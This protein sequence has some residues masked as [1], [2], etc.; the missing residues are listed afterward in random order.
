MQF[1]PVPEPPADRTLLATVRRALPATAGAVDDCCQRLVDETPLETRETAATWLTFLR[2]LEVASE[3]PAGF[4]RRDAS[5]GTESDTPD[6]RD[7]EELGRAFRERVYGAETVLTVL[8]RADGPRTVEEVVDAVREQRRAE[9][10]TRPSR[11]TE[12]RRERIERLLG[13]AV[14]FDLAERDRAG[15]RSIRASET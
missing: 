10:R 7:R 11:A 12:H 5:S 8:E 2:A 1:K 6:D 15:Y 9:D 14:M 3:E 13:W 4:R